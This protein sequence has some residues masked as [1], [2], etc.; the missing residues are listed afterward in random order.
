MPNS[1]SETMCGHQR[2]QE[3]GEENERWFRDIKMAR[4]AEAVA[5]TRT[6]SPS[7]MPSNELRHGLAVMRTA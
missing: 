5:C 7:V 4:K 2:P 1:S 6:S 3:A